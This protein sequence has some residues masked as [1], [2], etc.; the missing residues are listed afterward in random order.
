[1]KNITP[2]LVQKKPTRDTHPIAH[3]LGKLWKGRLG[4]LFVL[5]AF[6]FLGVFF[7][8]PAWT[9][10]SG[11]FTDWDGFNTPRFVGL[12]NFQRVFS[13]PVMGQA[14]L[15]NLIYAAVTI[16]IHTLFPFLAAELIFALKNHFS[17]YLYRS[18]FVIPLVVPTV[19]MIL[20]WMYFY[21]TEGTVN[22]ILNFLHLQNLT[23]TWLAEPATALGAI[24]LMGFPYVIPFNLLLL[25]TGL[26]S[27]PGE[28]YEAAEIDGCTPWRRIFSIDIPL[29]LPQFSLILMLTIIGST[30]NILAPLVMT[31]GGP[32]YSTTLPALYM[33]NTGVQ[34]GQ[35]GYS[36]A[37][38]FVL[39]LVTALF[40]VISQ[41]AQRRNQ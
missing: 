41:I 4:L 16:V 26:Q 14:A 15:N 24:I 5:P 11:A 7:Y 35:F 12:E 10:L 28:V 18:M 30:Q 33:Y 6:L 29:L 31:N 9:A 19:V 39:F 17:Q 8:Y 36:M 38:S 25:Y 32:G 1:M 3:L 20:L 27:I 40:S 37:Q 23:H 21:K 2:T 34:Y 22:Q 13:D